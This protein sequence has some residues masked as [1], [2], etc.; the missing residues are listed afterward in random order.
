MEN[1][2]SSQGVAW[3]TFVTV[4]ALALSTPSFKES[5]SQPGRNTFAALENKRQALEVRSL[6]L[7]PS[8]NT[9]LDAIETIL[10]TKEISKVER[11]PSSIDLY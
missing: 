8:N 1:S 2:K 9:S 4:V 10:K 3:L 7:N 11:N 5:V 6:P